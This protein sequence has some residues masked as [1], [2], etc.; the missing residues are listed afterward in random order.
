MK[1]P[2]FEVKSSEPD[3][4]GLTLTLTRGGGEP[5][6]RPTVR[7][8]ERVSVSMAKAAAGSNLPS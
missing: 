8:A 2:E 1:L 3:L 6:Q 5:E 4:L 7:R